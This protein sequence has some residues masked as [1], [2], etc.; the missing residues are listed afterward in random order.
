MQRPDR[1]ADQTVKPDPFPF[2]LV[3]FDRSHPVKNPAFNHDLSKTLSNFQSR[4]SPTISLKETHTKSRFFPMKW[5][6]TCESERKILFWW[7]AKMRDDPPFL[8]KCFFKPWG[9][10]FLNVCWVTVFGLRGPL[11]RP[12][13]WPNRRIRLHRQLFEVFARTTKRIENGIKH[14]H[15][16][17]QLIDTFQWKKYNFFFRIRVCFSIFSWPFWFKSLWWR[18]FLKS[19]AWVR[20]GLPVT[21]NILF[22]SGLWYFLSYFF[23]CCPW[24]KY[25]TCRILPMSLTYLIFRYC[26]IKRKKSAH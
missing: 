10:F 1:T 18:L 5:H 17:C 3:M 26:N 20:S 16:T 13:S 22:S 24:K 11:D 19:M 2:S 8:K 7:R 4:T 21:E 25:D 12:V 6:N 23:T 9:F 15:K 14:W